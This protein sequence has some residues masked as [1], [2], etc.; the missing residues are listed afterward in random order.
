MQY[1]KNANQVGSPPRRCGSPTTIKRLIA[2]VIA[3]LNLFSDCK[4]PNPLD[5]SLEI[6]DCSSKVRTVVTIMIGFSCP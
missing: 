2:R 6:S 3:T 4:N 5:A 1:F